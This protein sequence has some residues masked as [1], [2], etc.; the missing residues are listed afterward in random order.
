MPKMVLTARKDS[1]SLRIKSLAAQALKTSLVL[2][3]PYK[4]R[5][6]CLFS[7]RMLMNVLI[8][9]KN[10]TYRFSKI[11]FPYTLQNVRLSRSASIRQMSDKQKE[12]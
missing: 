4:V 6:T 10:T 1:F 5:S 11:S 2:Q 8:I 3:L 12:L 9:R 7:E